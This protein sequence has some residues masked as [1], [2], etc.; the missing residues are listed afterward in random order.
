V[1]EL[2]DELQH[3]SDHVIDMSRLPALPLP[4]STFTA[5]IVL[6]FIVLLL[7]GTSINPPGIFKCP[8]NNFCL[9]LQ[10]YAKGS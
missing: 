8:I 2:L 1:E 3:T 7:G 4:R 5:L 9:D 6:L 10:L